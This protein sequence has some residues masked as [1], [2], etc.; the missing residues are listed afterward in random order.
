[1]RQRFVFFRQRLDLRLMR[2]IVME[3]AKTIRASAFTI[4]SLTM[5][6]YGWDF[7]RRWGMFDNK[8][9]GAHGFPP[10]KRVDVTEFEL[11]KVYISKLLLLFQQI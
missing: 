7:H 8:V 10:Q 5:R 3:S 1:V 2:F 9:I 4:A 6:R 11:Q